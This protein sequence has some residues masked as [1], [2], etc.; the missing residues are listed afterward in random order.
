MKIKCV[1]FAS[2]YQRCRLSTREDGFTTS[3]K[4]IVINLMY[5]T[6]GKDLGR[7][8]NQGNRNL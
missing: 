4:I 1:A 5:F 3:Q 7:Q 2:F 6:Q 8:T